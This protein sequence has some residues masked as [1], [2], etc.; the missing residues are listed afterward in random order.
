MDARKE[1]FDSGAAWTRLQGGER[2]IAAKGKK[3]QIFDSKTDDRETILKS[4]MGPSGNL[5]APTLKIKEG[6]LIGF[7]SDLY[8]RWIRGELA[9]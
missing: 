4:V 5:R 3:V 9:Q 1:K 8:E 2:I 6:F 7:N